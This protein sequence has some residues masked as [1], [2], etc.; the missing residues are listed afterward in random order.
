MSTFWGTLLDIPP[1]NEHGDDPDWATLGSR[2]GTSPRITFQ[3]VQEP[4]ST[5]VR[6]HFD[7]QTHDIDAGRQQV[8][9]LGGRWSGIRYDYEDGVV[10]VMADPEGHEF[11]LVEYFDDATG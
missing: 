8:E 2:S 1:S 3:R 4:K 5:K 11:C 9:D 10:L 7:V 6:L